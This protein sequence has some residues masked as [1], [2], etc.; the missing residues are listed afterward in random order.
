MRQQPYA[1]LGRH[2]SPDARGG[3]FPQGT[4]GNVRVSCCNPSGALALCGCGGSGQVELTGEVTLDDNPI[5]AGAILLTPTDATGTA[6]GGEIKGGKYALTGER[7][8]RPGTYKV[9]IS[10][11]KKS[12]QKVQKAMGKPGELDDELVEAVAARFNTK[13]ELT[14]E[15]KAGSPTANVKASSK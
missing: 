2:R 15:V 14:V 9:S 5:E 7:A 10:A 4:T 11:N 13:T 8:P 3:H 12:G 6:T 1:A